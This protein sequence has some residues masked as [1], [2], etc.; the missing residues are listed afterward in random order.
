MQVSTHQKDQLTKKERFIYNVFHKVGIVWTV[1]AVYWYFFIF[2]SDL[3]F[4]G[5]LLLVSPCMMV[6]IFGW[7][8]RFDIRIMRKLN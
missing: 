1:G 3:S 6:T 8:L 7:A 5:I 2:E 4:F